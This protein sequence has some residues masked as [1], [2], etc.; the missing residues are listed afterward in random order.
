[1][2]IPSTSLRTGY[3]EVIGDPIAQSL[4]PVIHGFWLRALNIGADY[5]RTL[6]TRADF[7]DYLAKR[8]TDPD[9]RGCNVTMPLKLDA[10]ALADDTDD[11]SM[12]A[13]AAN[14]LIPREGRVLA[15]NTDVTGVLAALPESLMPRGAEVCVIGTGGAARAVLAALRIRDVALVM[16]SARDVHEG[17]VLLAEF[18]FDGC[19]HP[20]E[21][22]HH[23]E[24]AEVIINATPLGMVGQPQMP[25]GILENLRDPMPDAVVFDMVITPIE[26]ELLRAA[27]AQGLRTVRGVDM[28]VEQA[29]ESFSLL[30][31]AKPPRDRDAALL[32]ELGA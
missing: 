2:T 25:N 20:L 21:D 26:T 13:R 9:W 16:I 12:A 5:R 27:K 14:L 29:A 6:V 15:G 3:A 30:F 22:A 32:K 23:I 17:R 18:G 1:M 7:P 10:A 11:L 24:T 19:V 31:G 28:L 8:R 4:S